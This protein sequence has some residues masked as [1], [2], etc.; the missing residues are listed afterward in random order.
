MFPAGAQIERKGRGYLP[1]FII[2]SSRITQ[3]SFFLS[4]WNHSVATPAGL[5]IH[6]IQ[7][8]EQRTEILGIS[9]IEF[10]V[11]F[12]VFLKSLLLQLKSMMDTFLINEMHL[13]Q[14]VFFRLY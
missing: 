4:F 7:N 13:K 1:C 12:L 5:S 2:G 11:W 10:F 3:S 6:Q 14:N 8:L 9:E